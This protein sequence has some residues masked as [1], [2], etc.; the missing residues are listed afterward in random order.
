MDKDI[1]VE[2]LREDLN[3][4]YFNVSYNVRT[5][6]DSIYR[7]TEIFVTDQKDFNHET[8][9]FSCYSTEKNPMYV[10]GELD[11]QRKILMHIN[12]CFRMYKNGMSNNIKSN[13]DKIKKE[14]K[15]EFL[16]EMLFKIFYCLLF[17]IVGT[18]KPLLFICFIGAFI[19]WEI[20]QINKN[21]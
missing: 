14:T 7:Y 18:N 21:K 5:I 10:Q 15:Y 13:A 19:L 9:E 2:Y 11:Y 1:K 3:K 4:V 12:T 6:Y 8:L 20:R 17:Y 16:N